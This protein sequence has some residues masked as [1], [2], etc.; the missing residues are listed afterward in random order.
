V[1]LRLLEYALRLLTREFSKSLSIFIILTLM[2]SLL[3]SMLFIT[4]SMKYELNSTLDGLSDI[5]VQKQKAGMPTTMDESIVAEILEIPGVKSAHGRVWGYYYFSTAGVYFTLMGI[6]EFEQQSREILR[7]IVDTQSLKDSSMVVG[8]GVF[9]TLRKHYYHEY[10]N[11]ILENAETKR[12]SIVAT[13]SSA[14][15]LESNDIMV[16]SK[17]DVREIFGFRADEV[18]DIAIDVTN[19]TEVATIA[20]KLTQNYPNHTIITKDDMKVSYENIFN[21]K[22]GLFLGLFIVTFFTFFVILYDRL[23]GMSSVQKREI[24]I[25][26]ALGWRVKDILTSKLYESLLLS[27]FAYV[28]GVL[29]AVAFVYIF[30]APLLRDVFLGHQG[31]KPPFELL[32]VFDV[33]LLFL[34]FFLSVVPYVAAT[35]IPSWRV[36][37]LDADEVMR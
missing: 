35:I 1:N 6:D 37:T 16:M 15:R 22:S 21:Y 3:A 12:V 11:F 18:S 25:L 20:L 28:L 31:M 4:N 9:E 23:T 14:S 2:V 5:I 10:F 13:F 33:E 17:D 26:R 32:F 29:L 19:K 30:G 36:A 7:D 8:E 34:L 24:G 27:L